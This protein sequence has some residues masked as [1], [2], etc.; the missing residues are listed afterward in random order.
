MPPDVIASRVNLALDRKLTV[1]SR[2]RAGI[3]LR[4]VGE[5]TFNV[6][7]SNPTAQKALV[8]A[9]MTAGEGR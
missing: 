7:S 6:L 4:P 8:A 3:S 2:V 5:Y 9:R 1:P